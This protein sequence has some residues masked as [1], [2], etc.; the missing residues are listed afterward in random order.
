MRFFKRPDGDAERMSDAASRQEGQL[1]CSEDGC[2]EATAVGCGYVDRRSRRCSTAWCPRHRIVIDGRVYCRRHAGTVS[3]LPDGAQSAS[4]LPDLNNR[5]PSLVSWVAREVDAD[6]RTMLLTHAPE[7]SGAQ[8][9]AD[10][11]FLIF[12]GPERQRAW[13]RAWKLATHTG[14]SLRVALQVDEDADAEVAVKVGARVLGRFV[15]PWIAQ[16]IRG[17]KLSEEVDAQRRAE[18]NKTILDT[19]ARGLDHES[20]LSQYVA[21][22]EAM[23]RDITNPQKG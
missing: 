8:L 18:F 12:L 1:P 10:P 20:R 2:A 13:E 9:V 11:V 7:D 22:Q 16:R 15:P 6:I 19:I 14:L 21:K 3:A 5:A 23:M 4:P 17:E